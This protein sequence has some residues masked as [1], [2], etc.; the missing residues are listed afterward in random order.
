MI[1]VLVQ[2]QTQD[3]VLD[4]NLIDLIDKNQ[5]VEVQEL[6]YS[7]KDIKKKATPPSIT[8]AR[9]WAEEHIAFTRYTHI[10][11]C[12]AT[13]FK[14]LYKVQCKP[15]K[16]LGY[17]RQQGNTKFMYCPSV[18][19]IFHNPV[20][21]KE[22]IKFVIDSLNKDLNGTYTEPD[23][24]N[25]I[26][27]T[28]P[29]N[30]NDICYILNDLKDLP[31]TCDIETYSL[32]HWD[33]K[34]AS[35]AFSDTKYSGVSFKVD[36][37]KDKPNYP[38]RRILKKFFEY[39]YANKI[40]TIY[41]NACFDCY[42]LTYVL[43]M[44]E[45]FCN[46]DGL[47]KGIE[48][49]L[50]YFDDTKL[51]AYL[52]TNNASGNSLSL[53]ELAFEFAGNWG[54]PEDKITDLNS[55]DKNTLLSY[56]VTDTCATWYVYDKYFP[57]MVQDEQEDIYET[58]FKLACKDIVQMQLIGMP[59][60]MHQVHYVDDKLNQE[61]DKYEQIALSSKYVKDASDLIKN[62]L[63]IEKNKKLKTKKVTA[64]DIK[65]QFLLSSPDQLAI[66]VY[67]VCKFDLKELT[68]TGK[69]AT[70]QDVLED[71]LHTIEPND[72]RYELLD[73]IIN[74]QKIVKI[75]NTFLKEFKEAPQDNTGQHW[76]C[77]KFNLGGTVSG[78]LSSSD[79]NLQNLPSGSVYAKYIKSCFKAPKGYLMVGLDFASLEDHISA[80]TTK[81]KNKLKVY[82]EGYDSHCL[83][84]FAYWSHKM[85]DIQA[86]LDEIKKEGKVYKVTMGDG[87]VKYYNE[88]N[89][90]L[91]ELQ[92]EN[93]N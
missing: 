81:D 23:K 40:K 41:H 22:Q 3:S 77:G 12:D 89:P 90:E 48:I 13:Y 87:S 71:L 18:K 75:T 56:N 57:I 45:Q 64:Q 59:I 60:D 32:K 69:P 88:H 8:D 49:L 54:L 10:L 9:R 78:R 63:A 24:V 30:I 35:I 16:E 14:A 20:K 91:I 58:K 44:E 7:L 36:F 92:K 82:L 55:V 28:Y 34:I 46:W 33:A 85:P 31:L 84:S 53:K 19:T 21:A 72:D 15:E 5:E 42:V 93:H 61:K 70:G 67:E 68:K 76:L 73:A 80:L 6:W 86:E 17:I 4:S 66:L 27:G 47:L 52:A 1:L 25:E 43:F 26:L 37:T 39:R 29:E 62:R 50:T 65:F 38:L 2:P 83:R 79:P 74:W 11:V 51:I